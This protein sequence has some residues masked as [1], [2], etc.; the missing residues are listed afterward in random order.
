M[1]VNINIYISRNIYD[2]SAATL[3]K[4]KHTS[5]KVASRT[6]FTAQHSCGFYNSVQ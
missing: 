3:G 5:K 1:E 4:Q 6:I 2:V